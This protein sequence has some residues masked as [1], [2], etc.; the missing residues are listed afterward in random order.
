[1]HPTADTLLV[2]HVSRM[3]RPVM[4]GVRQNVRVVYHLLVW[5]K[6][7]QPVRGPHLFLRRP[8][9]RAKVGQAGRGA[10]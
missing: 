10:E 1:M 7:I 6:R 9:Q 5:L 4:P 3:G 2:I 8:R